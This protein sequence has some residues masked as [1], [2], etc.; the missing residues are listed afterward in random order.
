MESNETG[1]WYEYVKT[2]PYNGSVEGFQ[3]PSFQGKTA[4]EISNTLNN[5]ENWVVVPPVTESQNE[6][7]PTPVNNTNEEQP[8]VEE[9]PVDEGPV[10]EPAA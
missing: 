6:P 10:E 1:N 4:E 7:E 2:H 3:M 9:T 5:S 8:P